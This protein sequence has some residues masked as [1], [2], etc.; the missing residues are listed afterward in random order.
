MQVCLWCLRPLPNVRKGDEH[1]CD[2]G[3]RQA[4]REAAAVWL[5]HAVQVMGQ[6]PEF[7]LG[8]VQEGCP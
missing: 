2:G 5:A 1:L 6:D 3:C 7:D 8:A 4:F